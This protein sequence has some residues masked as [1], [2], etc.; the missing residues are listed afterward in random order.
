MSPADRTVKEIAAVRKAM[1][2]GKTSPEDGEKRI[3]A[4]EKRGAVY[5]ARWELPNGRERTKSFSGKGAEKR[6][7][8]HEAEQKG[9]VRRRE[10]DDPAGIR[11]TVA[12]VLDFYLVK[13]AGRAS[14]KNIRAHRADI[15]E[16]WGDRLTL[17]KLD[18]SPDTLID[19]LRARLQKKQDAKTAWNRKVT[20]QAAITYYLRKKRLRMINPFLGAD[21]PQPESKRTQAPDYRDF[22]AMVKEAQ[23]P[24]YP[25]WLPALFACGW[26]HALRMGEYLSWR[27]EGTTLDPAGNDLPW[28]KTEVEKQG[29]GKKVW[30]ELPLTR[31]AAQ[32]LRSIPVAN[33]E[34]G[35]VFPLKRTMVDRWVRR[36]LDASG[37]QGFNFHDFRR[38]W[39]RRH[40]HLSQRLRMEAMGQKSTKSDEHY[41]MQMERKQLEEIV[42]DSWEK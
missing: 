39:K 27:W 34:T 32:A 23:K 31:D 6:A 10:H 36:A 15:L 1:A 11:A 21:W 25:A 40:P 41:L 2:A 26:E 17:E 3:Q 4:L 12:A 16:V 35:P 24:G 37:N 38:S 13:M 28:V 19:E 22:Q 33:K 42:R 7:A 8:E 20:A 29:K 14:I 30:R 5:V 9:K 18:R